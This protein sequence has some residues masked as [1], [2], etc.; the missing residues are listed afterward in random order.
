MEQKKIKYPLGKG[1]YERPEIEMCKAK[2]YEINDPR[3]AIKIFEQKIA[4]FTGAKYAVA[5]DNLTDGLFLCLQMLIEYGVERHSTVT[6]PKRTYCSVP[7][8]I[9]NAEYELKF[10]PI[11][12]KGIYQLKPFPIW[13]CAVSFK[14]DMYKEGQLMVLSFQHKKRLCI[15]KGGMVLT[16]DEDEYNWLVAA[17]YEGRN[18]DVNQWDDEYS[19]IGWNMYMSPDDAA[20]GILIFD[21]LIE[22]NTNW[23]D[24]AGSENYP[25]LSTKKIFQKYVA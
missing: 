6:I 17:R 15:G 7:M 13:D 8:T 16:D 11:E 9:L 12:W 3:D 14:K 4:E 5:V 19:M 10:E 22:N 2:G 20:R 25:D 18:L 21:D 1:R 23:E 24:W